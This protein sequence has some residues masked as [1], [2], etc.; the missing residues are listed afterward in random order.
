TSL[1]FSIPYSQLQVYVIVK[2]TNNQ[3]GNNVFPN[4][5]LLVMVNG[6]RV[7]NPNSVG[8]SKPQAE[9]DNM[10]I[11]ETRVGDEAFVMQIVVVCDAEDNNSD[12][13]S[14]TEDNESEENDEDAELK[15]CVCRYFEGG[16]CYDG[17]TGVDKVFDYHTSYRA[18]AAFS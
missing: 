16:D 5:Y 17:M 4:S 9:E 1:Q 11:E 7:W 10:E 6:D 14:R 13:D 18:A 15:N 3:T 2:N 12:L 8:S